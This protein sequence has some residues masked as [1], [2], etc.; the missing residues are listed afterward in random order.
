MILWEYVGILLIVSPKAMENTNRG[1]IIIIIII[2][3][4]TPSLGVANYL[5]GIK[6]Y[7]Y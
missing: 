2:G 1:Y 7:G 4:Q 6:F 5:K 3:I